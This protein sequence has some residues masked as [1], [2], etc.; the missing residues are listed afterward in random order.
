MRVFAMAVAMAIV[1]GLLVAQADTSRMHGRDTTRGRTYRSSAGAI[2]HRNYGLSQD[3]ISQLQTALKQDNCNPGAID[4]ILGPRTRS[5]MACA[6]RANNVTGNNPNDLFRSLNLGFTTADSTGGRGMRG[7]N[8]SAADTS[9]SNMRMRNDSTRRGRRGTDGAALAG[10]SVVLGVAPLVHGQ[11][12][13]QQAQQGE[14]DRKRLQRAPPGQWTTPPCRVGAAIAGR[15]ERLAGRSTRCGEMSAAVMSSLEGSARSRGRQS[16]RW[17]LVGMQVADLD[18]QPSRQRL[19][20]ERAV[21]LRWIGLEAQQADPAP[22][23]H[24]L[25]ELAQLRLGA[26]GAEVI[27][28]DGA[29][30]TGAARASRGPAGRG[31]AQP[32]QMHVRDAGLGQVIGQTGLAESG[33][34]GA[35]HGAHIHQQLDSGGGQGGQERGHRRRLVPDGGDGGTAGGAQRSA[36]R[37]GTRACA[38]S[39][40]SASSARY[41]LRR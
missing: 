3:Q 20:H 2:G 9:M 6:R 32:A 26:V 17:G 33:P 11:R 30:P 8:R 34:T 41:T 29:H 18:G 38:A 25:L 5:A 39:S 35:G 19:R 12:R 10:G 31:G 14:R 24:E 40:S 28:E 22:A 13:E 15:L 4:G 21:T 23:P 36:P 37:D 1:P 7:M 27:E 16:L